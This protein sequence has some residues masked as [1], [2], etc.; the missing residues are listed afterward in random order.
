MGRV[1]VG[2]PHPGV[3]VGFPHPGVGVGFPHP[4]VEQDIEAQ[5]AGD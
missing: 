5:R 2:F 3:G 4:G 1:G